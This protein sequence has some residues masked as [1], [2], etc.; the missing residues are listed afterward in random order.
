MLDFIFKVVSKFLM[1]SAISKKMSK[2]WVS[3]RET[4]KLCRISCSFFELWTFFF[5]VNASD[6]DDDS[7]VEVDRNMGE[8]N[9]QEGTVYIYT[10]SVMIIIIVDGTYI[11]EMEIAPY[12][13]HTVVQTFTVL[14]SIFN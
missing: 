13:V 12:S 10:H 1:Y 11:V 14:Q 7:D 4:L 5:F 6:F 2:T 9:S 3:C 8:R